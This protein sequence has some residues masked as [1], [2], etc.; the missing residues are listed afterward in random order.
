MHIHDTLQLEHRG[1]RSATNFLA[2]RDAVFTALSG[3]ARITPAALHCSEF[4]DCDDRG[5]EAAASK[6]EFEL[7]VGPA[8]PPP[9]SSRSSKRPRWHQVKQ[10][11]PDA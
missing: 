2:A 8:Q 6:T 3:Y 1:H 4:R 5:G 10:A 7:A 9:R 11:V